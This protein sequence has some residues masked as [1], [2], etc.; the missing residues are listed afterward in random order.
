MFYDFFFKL[1]E[2]SQSL[3]HHQSRISLTYRGQLDRAYEC[4]CG[5][6]GVGGEQ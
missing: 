3:E 5:G 1:H 2:G 4:V 6:A